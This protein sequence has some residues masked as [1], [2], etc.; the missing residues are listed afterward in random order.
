MNAR[1]KQTARSQVDTIV[2]QA[3]TLLTTSL[4][5]LAAVQAAEPDWDRSGQPPPIEPRG[6]IYDGRQHQPTL[7]DVA[8]REKR[9][10]QRLEPGS[11]TNPQDDELYRRVLKDV[12]RDLPKSLDPGDEPTNDR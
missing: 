11:N 1:S 4:L 9:M 7:D 2:I 12:D 8:A 3:A 10:G 6:P 5:L